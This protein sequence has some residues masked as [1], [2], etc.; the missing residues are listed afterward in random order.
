VASRIFFGGSGG[1]EKISAE[2]AKPSFLRRR[3]LAEEKSG[4]GD[5]GGLGL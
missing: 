2:P 3:R 5:G 4:G 1:W